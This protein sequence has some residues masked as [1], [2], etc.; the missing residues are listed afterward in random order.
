[1]EV[2]KDGLMCISFNPVIVDKQGKDGVRWDLY[3]G[4]FYLNQ[5]AK[6]HERRS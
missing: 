4:S 3:M 1:M 6:C 5:S 2:L